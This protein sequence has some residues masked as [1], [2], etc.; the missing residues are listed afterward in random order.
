MAIVQ[1]IA[2]RTLCVSPVKEYDNT[3]QVTLRNRISSMARESMLRSGAKT[4]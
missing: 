4:Q 2:S 1:G 3:T